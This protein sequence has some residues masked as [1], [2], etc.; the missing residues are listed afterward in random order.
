MEQDHL[1]DAV[2]QSSENI[3]SQLFKPA[4]STFDT[5]GS[6][7]SGSEAAAIRNVVQTIYLSGVNDV[8]RTAGGGGRSDDRGSLL[9]TK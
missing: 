8:R 2:L 9:D 4:T 6:A 3:L 7:I 5:L 1:L